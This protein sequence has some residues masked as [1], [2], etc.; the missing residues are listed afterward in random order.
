[1]DSNNRVAFIRFILQR[2]AEEF[3]IVVTFDPK[4]MKEWNGAG[5]HTNFS[6]EAMRQSGGIK[7][8]ISTFHFVQI[9]FYL[10]NLFA[11]T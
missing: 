8:V 10:V 6:T 5:A 4:P 1:M 7:C 2:L 11:I 3:G 9:F